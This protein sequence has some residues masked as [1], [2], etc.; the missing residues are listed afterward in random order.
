MT[1]LLCNL[2][3]M[4]HITLASAD[5]YKAKQGNSLGPVGGLGYCA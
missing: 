5:G 4:K 2:P 1:M 3:T